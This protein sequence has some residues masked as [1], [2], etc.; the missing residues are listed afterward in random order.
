MSQQLFLNVDIY[1]K[2]YTIPQSRR[3]CPIWIYQSSA[4]KMEAEK[5]SETLAYIYQAT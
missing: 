3:L 1:L 5:S 4:L 2:D